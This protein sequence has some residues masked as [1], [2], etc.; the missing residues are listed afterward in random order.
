MSQAQRVNGEDR[1]KKLPADRKSGGI[2]DEFWLVVDR[3]P[4][5]LSEM[6]NDDSCIIT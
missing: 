1:P 4:H 3:S 5:M 2:P 6:N